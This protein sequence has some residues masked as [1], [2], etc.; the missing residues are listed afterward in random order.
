MWLTEGDP[1]KLKGLGWHTELAL[2]RLGEPAQLAQAIGRVS[3]IVD[4]YQRAK[5]M[6][7]L[8][9]IRHADV[10]PVILVVLNSDEPY[11]NFG[12]HVELQPSKHAATALSSPRRISSKYSAIT[13]IR[14]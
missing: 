8:Q 7:S 5:Q 3:A 13:R 6:D 10:V 11:R 9:Y 4:I 12:D 2:A 14:L 1:S